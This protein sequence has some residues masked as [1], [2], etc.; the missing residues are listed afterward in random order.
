MDGRMFFGS[1]KGL[2]SFKPDEFIRNT[3]IPPVY[4]TGLEVNNREISA[5]MKNSPLKN[6]LFI[7]IHFTS[8]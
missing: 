4:I 5:N 8:L 3:D 1:G 2:I 6:P 7:Q